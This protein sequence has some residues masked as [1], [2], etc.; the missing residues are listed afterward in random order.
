MAHFNLR[1]LYIFCRDLEEMKHFYSDLLEMEEFYYVAGP[2]GGLAY[3]CDGLQFT[4]FPTQQ[5]LEVVQEWHRQ[6]GWPGGTSARA[7]WSVESDSHDAYAAAIARLHAAGVPA[8]FDQPQWIGYWS[9]PV[10]DPMGN[11]VEV[12]LPLDGPPDNPIWSR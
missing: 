3:R 1:F 4:I 2:D 9:F 7:S 6:P 11:T 10:K 5:P 8:F 12:V